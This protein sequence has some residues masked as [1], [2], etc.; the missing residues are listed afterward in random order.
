VVSGAAPFDPE[1]WL[2]MLRAVRGDVAVMLRETTGREARSRVVGAGAGGDRTVAIDAAAEALLVAA[3]ETVHGRT[4]EPVELISEELGVRR[5]GAV[6]PQSPRLVVDPIDGSLN[7]KRGLP[8]FAFSAAVA[9][10][11]TLADVRLG[12]VA[13]FGTGQEHVAVLGAG[14]TLDGVPVAREPVAPGLQIVLL[15]SANPKL[16]APIVAALATG[17]VHRI[18][19]VGSLALTVVHLG[20]GRADAMIAPR[21]GRS[22]DVAA[23]QLIARE[24]GAV[25]AL[26]D[27][28][29]GED[30][31]L[32]DAPLDLEPRTAIL[33]AVTESHLAELRGLVGHLIVA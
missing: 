14:G 23:A 25:L 19:A 27:P 13:D 9:T 18:R 31:P 12:Y 7:A 33:G 2:E 5:F 3:L 28:L 8:A 15:E 22:V 11:T 20:L 17:R 4:G 16:L 10:G 30:V 29:T 1:P 6:G 21:A 26:I 32:E 24:H